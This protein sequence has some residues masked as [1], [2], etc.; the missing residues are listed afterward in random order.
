MVK[1]T[2]STAGGP[3]KVL[4]RLRASSIRGRH[5]GQVAGSRGQGGEESDLP[6]EA[7]F[8]PNPN[9]IRSIAP[10]WSKA[11]R[12]G[13]LAFRVGA[14]PPVGTQPGPRSGDGSGTGVRSAE[15]GGKGVVVRPQFY[16][17]IRAGAIRRAR[18]A[19]G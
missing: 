16:A 9:K 8:P 13:K 1:L 5:R 10:P 19:S 6:N 12:T 14:P 17:S 3:T 15:V 7:I 11:I 18:R 4:V 2:E